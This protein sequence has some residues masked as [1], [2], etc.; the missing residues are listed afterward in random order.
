[1]T[2]MLTDSIRLFL[3]PLLMAFSAFSDLFTMTIS[4]RVSILLVAGFAVMA[5]LTGMNLSDVLSHVGAGLLVLAITFTFFA[6]GWIGGGD[7]KL[8][9]ATAL[10]LGFAPL[11]EYLLIASI[12]G[13]VI[14]L[15]IMRFRLMPLPAMLQGQEWA[16]RLHR[17]DAGVPYGI[18][19]AAAAI[20]VYPHTIW[21]K[22]LGL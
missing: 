20:T 16:L 22:P 21:M 4:N 14:T 8:A 1:M 11:M 2:M 5:A 12:F 19:L 18:A 3:F 10:W 15:V 6:C 9:A 17:V 7:A 13:G